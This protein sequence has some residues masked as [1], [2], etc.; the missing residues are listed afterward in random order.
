MVHNKSAATTTTTLIVPHKTLITI[1]VMLATIMQ[2]LDST[3]ANV[4]LPHMQGT[5]SATQD[6]MSWVL[7][8]YIVSAAIMIPLTGWLAGQF[9][10]RKIFL[11]SIAGFTV[12]SALCGMASSLP[13]I[14]LFR[15]MQGV[16]GAALVPLSQAVLFDINR[17][18]DF[19]RAMAIWGVGVTM[20]PILG[21]ALGGWLTENYNWR[22]V[23]YINL[24]I[25]IA[26][27]LGLWY[28]LPENKNSE[29]QKFDFFGFFSLSLMIASLQ[30]ML[31][32]G[33]LKDWFSDSE[34]IIE[35]VLASVG[36]YWI[37]IQTCSVP[38]P[39]INPKLFADRNFLISNIFIFLVGIILFAT[40]A[41]LPPMLQNQLN[42]PVVL[43]GLVTAPR[44]IGTMSAM[45]LVGYLIK[46]IDIRK[47][48]AAG[49]ILTAYSLWKMAHFSLTM[50]TNPIIISGLLQGFGIGLVYVPLSTVA[51]ATLAANLR[52]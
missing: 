6:Q 52:T 43:T 16:F 40:M 30:I 18:E 11:I 3:I 14:V 10:R 32:R 22:F 7:T 29:R 21:P 39:F 5:L 50:D 26:A 45:M 2:A 41:L 27:L 37:C 44:G 4:A 47:I 35:A 24:P 48:I 13:Q 34:I 9:G 19:G 49:L 8:S 15:I 38:K 46:K 33:Q 25:G 36:F 20:G 1:C 17:K 51:F 23:F 12:A 31:D 42:Y 28:A